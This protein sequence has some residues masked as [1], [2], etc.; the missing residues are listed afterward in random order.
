MSDYKFE[1]GQAVYLSDLVPGEVVSRSFFR[2][3]Q[4]EPYYVVAK[5][6]DGIGRLE[7]ESM[8]T[9]RLTHQP[10]NMLFPVTVDESDLY[11]KLIRKLE[12]GEM[13]KVKETI[14]NYGG[15]WLTITK[16]TTFKP[17]NPNDDGLCVYT[18]IGE[19]GETAPGGFAESHID[20]Y[21]TNLRLIETMD[22]RIKKTIP[23]LPTI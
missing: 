17:V 5:D 12:V 7:R 1:V 6:I 9:A 4:D 13:F 21:E 14:F 16:V 10:V 11:G 20:I 3:I 22:R 2:G 15:E 19:H 8:L 18:G 23:N